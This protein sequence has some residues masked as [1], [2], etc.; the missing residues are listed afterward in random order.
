[1]KREAKWQTIFNQYLRQVGSNGYG[2]YELKQTRTDSIPFKN[3][4]DHQIDSL[5]ASHQNGLIWKWSDQDQREKPV[6]CGSFPPLQSY[7]VIKFPDG[8]Y[9][10][11]IKDFIKER[12]TSDRESLTKENAFKIAKKV[13]HI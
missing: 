1:M 12:D 2:Y 3:V 8:F 10:I 6:D 13:I 11:T 9:V 7:I 5:L 4:K